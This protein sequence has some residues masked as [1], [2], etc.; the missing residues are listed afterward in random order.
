V[1]QYRLVDL[2][3]L[4]ANKVRVCESLEPVLWDWGFGAVKIFTCQLFSSQDFV[5]S[6]KVLVGEIVCTRDDFIYSIYVRGH[7]RDEFLGDLFDLSLKMIVK[8]S[9]FFQVAVDGYGHNFVLEVGN[10][11]DFID[12]LFFNVHFVILPIQIFFT[13]VITNILLLVLSSH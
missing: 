13:T 2:L 6:L 1:L 4:L 12:D 5:D 10:L 11:L 3:N 8:L 9:F 7:G